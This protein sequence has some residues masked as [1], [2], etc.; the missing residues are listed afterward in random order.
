MERE[1][2]GAKALGKVDVVDDEID[3]EAAYGA[4]SAAS[5]IATGPIVAKR[6]ANTVSE[7]TPLLSN[8][9]VEDS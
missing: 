2:W 1:L 3:R 5:G 4:A 7:R 8:V 9:T 6:E